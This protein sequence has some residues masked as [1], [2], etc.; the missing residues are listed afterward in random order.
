MT[1]TARLLAFSLAA[2]AIVLAGFSTALHV[3]ASVHSHRSAGQ[4]LG[5]TLAMLAARVEDEPDGLD[6]E[7]GGRREALADDPALEGVGW[8]VRDD[9]G[10][11]VDRSWVHASL[12]EKPAARR[13][14]PEGQPWRVA[15]RVVRSSTTDGA[16]PP[17]STELVL[18]AG[19]RLGPAEA[20]LGR[21]AIALALLSGIV[22]LL[23]AMVGWRVCRRA[24]APLRR[25]A[26]SARD[27]G[28]DDTGAR[29]PVAT[30]ADELEDL[31]HAFNGLIDRWHDALERQARFA[32]DASHQLRTPLTAVLGQVE[33]ALRRD[34]PPEEYRR[35]LGL[36]HD[37]SD[38]LRRIVEALLFLARSEPEARWPDPDEFDL[39]DWVRDQIHRREAMGCGDD[40][41]LEGST[42]DP[43]P[44]RA[45]PILLAQVLDNLLDNARQ[46]A[47]PGSTVV[48][49]IAREGDFVLLSVEDRGQGIAPTDLARLFEPFHRSASA[50]RRNRSGAGLGLAVALQIA[51]AFGGDLTAES[52]TGQGSRFTLRLPSGGEAKSPALAA[53]RRIRDHSGPALFDIEAAP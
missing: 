3:G 7:A 43:A 36:V 1:L 17:R 25:M 37:Q 12:P 29:L 19:L 35:V 26:A 11:L 10:R 52:V 51:R 2:L 21:L 46:Y 24:L 20:E 23:A 40:V 5:S 9:R 44:I 13:L 30:T 6:W 28:A 4:R 15:S 22:W 48:V 41:R 32:G 50:R 8:I 27:L 14:D 16:S 42:D 31:G 33:V 34:R 53:D 45:Q 47:D 49:R 39:V 18:T 38:R